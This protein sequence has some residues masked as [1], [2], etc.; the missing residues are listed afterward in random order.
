MSE[1][2]L[3]ILQMKPKGLSEV[4]IVHFNQDKNRQLCFEKSIIKKKQ[5]K[6]QQYSWYMTEEKVLVIMVGGL[7]G[8]AVFL[9]V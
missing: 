7:A 6:L 4:N 1:C 8:L 5:S 2:R 9:L 3:G